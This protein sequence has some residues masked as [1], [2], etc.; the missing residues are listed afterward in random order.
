MKARLT[1]L[2]G[3]LRGAQRTLKDETIGIGGDHD[4]TIYLPELSSSDLLALIEQRDCTYTISARHPAA[5][6]S[7]NGVPISETILE[8]GDLVEIAGAHTF[9]FGTVPEHGEPCKALRQIARQSVRAAAHFDAGHLRR[10]AFLIRD[11][12]HCIACDATRRVKV[13]CVATCALVVLSAFIAG[14]T[15]FRATTESDRRVVA[16]SEQVAA[17]TA[18][19]HRLEQQVARVRQVEQ[20]KALADAR[21]GEVSR[22][23][24]TA[25]QR[26]ARL[27][28]QTPDLLAA[29]DNARQSVAFLLVGYALY[30]KASGKPL[31]F[32]SADE[33]AG[34]SQGR[35]ETS[36]DGSG[37]IVTSYATGSGCLGTGGR[38][39]TNRHVA[40]PW[41]KDASV[42]GAI[43]N[44]F[45]P[46]P[47]VLH[48][49]FTG[50]SR[51]IELRITSLSSEA[52]IA[53]LAA[54]MAPTRSPLVLAPPERR[55]TV[56][57]AIVVVGYP[58]GF[59]ALLAKTDEAVARQIVDTAG[60]DWPALAHM[61]AE[62]RLITPLVTMG[63]VGDT[64][65]NKIV[66]DAATTYGSSGGP[67]LNLA[68]EVIALNYAGLE[69]FAGV[70][71][72]IPVGLVHRLLTGRRRGAR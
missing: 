41:W 17:G 4:H 35:Y 15:L 25:E 32:A 52:D 57:D 29:I 8:D 63:H 30:E 27:E 16:L 22:S 72:G 6:L 43:A 51:P 7:I 11:V 44:G 9:R 64:A 45:E 2:S 21:L 18:S 5:S 55:V 26:L 42:D 33:T 46:R 48:A 39:V 31:R 65:E 34:S 3:S 50:L 60:E 38:I 36:V 69:Q 10:G 66:Y 68:G 23:L 13:A 20:E 70:R 28:Q 40:Q 49:Y 47:T 56:G 37:P 12:C 24:E 54:V 59:E 58:T 61:L 19:R 67:V 53:V 71:F 1:F 14:T 62:K